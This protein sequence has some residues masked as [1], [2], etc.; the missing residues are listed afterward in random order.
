M[1]LAEPGFKHGRQRL[2]GLLR[3]RHGESCAAQDAHLVVQRL[4]ADVLA[5]ATC[6]IRPPVAIPPSTRWL[7]QAPGS[8]SGTR[9]MLTSRTHA[10][11]I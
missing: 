9:R 10:A 7:A 1:R 2:I 4:M 3:A 6:A 5:H 8:A 11:P